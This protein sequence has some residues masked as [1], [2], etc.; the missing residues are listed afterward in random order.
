MLLHLAKKVAKGDS[1][2]LITG[3]SGTG[4][5]ISS[6]GKYTMEVK[7]CFKKNLL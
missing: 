2:V 7:R 1:N 3:E 4:K 6:S 5:E